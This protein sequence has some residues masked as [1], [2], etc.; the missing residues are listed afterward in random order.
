MS[1]ELGKSFNRQYVIRIPLQNNYYDV[2]IFLNNK[3][4]FSLFD[5][6]SNTKT[7]TSNFTISMFKNIQGSKFCET[8]LEL[9][10]YRKNF[11]DILNQFERIK[12]SSV[13]DVS[14]LFNE[15]IRLSIVN[16]GDRELS[17]VLSINAFTIN[18][19]SD[20]FIFLLVERQHISKQLQKKI[21]RTTGCQIASP[22]ALDVLNQHH[23]DY[24]EDLMW[25]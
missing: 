8:F 4:V 18:S 5:V 3:S 22:Y 19:L 16:I 15:N 9:H 6:K 23:Q 21:V 25:K 12:D 13:Q 14:F 24:L 1:L 17:D 20:E 7:N 11:L 10:S 2:G